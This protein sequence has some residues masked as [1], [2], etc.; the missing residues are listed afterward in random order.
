MATR[1]CLV[2]MRQETSY[3]PLGVLGYCLRRSDFLAPVW[4]GLT[5]PMKQV[6]HAPAAKLLDVVVSML[7]GCRG[8]T[9][10]NT[11]L[12]PDV[13]LAQAWGRAQFAEQSTLARTLD[14]MSEVQV[15]QLRQGTTALF[16]RESGVFRHDFGQSWLWLDI[17]LTP[18]PISKQA[19]G[20]TKG[21]FAKK[22]ATVGNWPASMPR[23][24]TRRSFPTSTPASR[25]VA[26]RM[27][28]FWL[29]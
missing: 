5:L 26:L 14:A 2:S 24:I 7:T 17:D 10:V 25:T 4:S 11:R 9:Q 27:C 13:A 6:V 3:A 19:E 29:P 23:S 18:L 16:H 12:R 8:I 15:D 21:K 20:S 1:I 28:R 22:T